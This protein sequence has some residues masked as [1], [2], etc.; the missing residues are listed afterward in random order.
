MSS[1]SALISIIIPV[2][3]VQDYLARCLDSVVNQTYKNF[4]IILVND[5][6]SDNS[7]EI[8]QQYVNKDNRIILIDKE[9]GGLSSARNAGLDI[10]KGEYVTFIDSDDWVDLDYV[11]TLHQDIVDNNADI[12]MAGFINVYSST[13]E[14]LPNI[15]EIK[16]FSREESINKLI[17]NK[18]ET[19]A[20]SKLFKS[21]LFERLRF[22]EG[23]IFED[24]DIMYKL[25]LLSTKVVRNSSVRYFYFQRKSSIMGES[26]NRDNLIETSNTYIDIFVSQNRI[27]K[28]EGFNLSDIVYTYQVSILYKYYLVC[29]CYI[30][31][32]EIFSQR[33]KIIY[34]INNLLEST[35]NINKN[36]FYMYINIVKTAFNKVLRRII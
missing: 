1:G 11:A 20:C 28:E 10:H 9:K 24:L 4:E 13:L 23:I 19:S 30:F 22:R 27:L 21:F 2:Y 8:C 17:L 6:S 32:K 29:S 36:K 5:G 31:D 18:L 14:D 16:T 7:L 12:S 34:T 15:N 25:F 35:T 33:K 3:N 26:K